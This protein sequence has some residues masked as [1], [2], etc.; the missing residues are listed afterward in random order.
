MADVYTGTRLFTGELTGAGEQPAGTYAKTYG[1]LGFRVLEQLLDD[2]ANPKRFIWNSC[3]K[4]DVSPDNYWDN[5]KVCQG[6]IAA[7][8][9]DNDVSI[10]WY[11]FTEGI[12]SRLWE[13]VKGDFLR[14]VN[15]QVVG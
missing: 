2:H 11:A 3:R 12:D 6:E 10:W 13:E 5:F 1:E 8:V 4:E 7:A 9:K 14:A 15:G